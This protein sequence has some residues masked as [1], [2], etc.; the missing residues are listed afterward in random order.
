LSVSTRLLAESAAFRTAPSA[1]LDTL[2]T[3]QAGR[4]QDA[5]N[6]GFHSRVLEEGQ[7]LSSDSRRAS[8]TSSWLLSRC[9]QQLAH[10]ER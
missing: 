10:K 2:P 1:V 3:Q 9:L 6:V 8:R 7:L 5:V 4:T